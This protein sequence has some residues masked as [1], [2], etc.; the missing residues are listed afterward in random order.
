MRGPVHFTRAVGPLLALAALL[1]PA[2]SAAQSAHPVRASASGQCMNVAG[3]SQAQEAAVIQWPCV[4]AANEQ[5][6]A[7]FAGGFYTLKVR[8]SGQCLDVDKTSTAAGASMIQWACSGAAN[9]QFTLRPVRDG[10]AMVA[11]HSNLCVGISG[12]V[13]TQ[14]ARLTQQACNGSAAQTWNVP[15]TTAFQSVSSNQCMNVRG[16]STALNAAVVQ[17]PCVGAANEQWQMVQSG[18]F[19]TLRSVNSGLC[20]D[21]PGVSRTAGTAL[22]QWTCVPGAQNEQFQ[23]RAQ[24]AGFALVARHSGQ[25]VAPAAASQLQDT[26]L[27]QQ[28]C[29][30]STAQTWRLAGFSNAPQAGAWGPVQNLSLVPVAAA[31]LPN[32]NV[33]FWSAFDR[34]TF[35]GDNGRTYTSIYNPVTGAATERLVTNTGHDMFC[36]GIANLP[37]GRIHV[38]GGSSAQSTSIYDPATNAW[39]T[40]APMNIARGYQGS[41]TLGNG[42]VFTIGGS[43]SGGEGNKDAEVWSAAT[44]TWR[45]TGAIFDDFIL[46][47]DARGIYRSDNHAWL[48]SGPGGRVFHAGP[49]RRMN[50]FTTGGAGTVAAAGTRGNDGDAMNGFAVM[51]DANRILTT[52]GAPNYENVNATP[53]AHVIDIGGAAVATK[54][55][56]RMQYAR[57]FHNNV[58]LP[59]GQVVVIGGQT[60]P[61]P[62]SDDR[63]V[64]VPELYNPATETFTPMAAM[65]QPRTYHSVALLL[66]DARVLSG[67]GGLCGGCTTNHPNVQIWSPPYLFNADG[68]AATRPAITAAPAVASAGTAMAVNTGTAVTAFSLVRLSSV[69]HSVNNEQRRLNVPFTAA[70]TNQYTLALNAD[71]GVLVPGFY[72]LFAMNAQ[73]VPSVARTLRIN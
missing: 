18:G 64:L 66:P 38:S 19:Y 3:N 20:L 21:V 9:Q 40:A 59:N 51:F 46:T 55:V 62:F 16:A 43:W 13:G 41:L 54:T 56:A 36:P 25:C 12:A 45:R 15:L 22:D 10:F 4:G 50:W 7:D 68:S 35:G 61:A 30:G 60:F 34:F 63:A 14:G 32:G 5:W 27:V 69:T 58:V 6:Q 37:D 49:S 17:W 8:H 42:D 26:N 70:G 39:T 29:N 52:G 57:A 71:R 2:V 53:N 23:L 48:F 72:M 73:G 67:G 28:V 33:L 24:G 65:A 11:R 31:N 44:G 47:A 1:L